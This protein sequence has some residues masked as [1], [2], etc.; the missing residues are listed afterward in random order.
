MYDNPK[1][2]IDP[3]EKKI[4]IVTMNHFWSA[5]FALLF[6]HIA[7]VVAFPKFTGGCNAVNP[8]GDP[9]TK[10]SASGL[11]SSLGLQLQIGGKTLTPGKAFTVKPGKLLTIAIKSTGGK[12]FRGFQ[13]RI[14][15]GSTD[16]TTW[17]SIGKD[18][19]VQVD[20]FCTMKKVGGISH[21]DKTDKSNV[22]GILKVPSAATGITIEVTIVVDDK[23]SIWYKSDYKV[24][25][26]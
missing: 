5:L 15:Q 10:A 20:K 4:V 2:K 9:H 24:V 17:L 22:A 1:I 14:S 12:T 16:T 25:A 23:P 13:I 6:L 8:L 19:F 7:P 21:K 11:L 18:P 3:N 26:K